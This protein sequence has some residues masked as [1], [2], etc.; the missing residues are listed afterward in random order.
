MKRVISLLI[1]AALFIALGMPALGAPAAASNRVAILI[2]FHGT[3][4]PALVESLGGKVT[5]AY[6]Y[7]PAVAAT[8]PEVILGALRGNAKVAYVEPDGK[9]YAMAQTL[10]WGVDRIDADLV[11]ATANKGTGVKVAILDTGI[12]LAHEDLRVWGGANFIST[13]TSYDDDNGHGT[14]CAGIVAALDNTVGVIGVA[15]EAELYA[16]KVLDSAGS[17]SW[18]TV[19]A[20]IE[21]AIT[22][23]MQII[24]MS[25]GGSQGSTTLEAACKK[26]WDAG[27]LLVAAAGNSG[28]A[29]GRND[30]VNY[31][32]KYPTVIAV[33]ATDSSDK[34]PSWSSTGPAVELAAPGVSIPSTY[35]GNTYKALSGTSMACPHVA[36]VA[37]LVWRAHPTLT[38]QQVRDKMNATA[39][40]L[41]VVG[42]D[43]WYGFGLVYAPSAVR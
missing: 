40:D 17:G 3:P 9:C 11:H 15:P 28:N 14:H 16:V 42:R 35:I 31:P 34:R 30:T 29:G 5:F 26:A 21:W 4:D 39:I 20:G 37:A 8:V 36:G 41:G 23:K 2:G 13:A 18:S 7:V 25:L 27:I 19:A 32:A 22:N 33:A 6:R 24:S 1:T 10:P 43:T 12:A 38:N